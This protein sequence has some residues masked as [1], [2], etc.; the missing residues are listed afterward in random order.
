[1]KDCPRGLFSSLG[2]QDGPRSPS[3]LPVRVLRPPPSPPHQWQQPQNPRGLQAVLL[4]KDGG[5]GHHTVKRPEPQEAKGRAL[6]G[7]VWKY[8]L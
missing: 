8:C 4:P 1:M 3:W 5:Q 2:G 6:S 7:V